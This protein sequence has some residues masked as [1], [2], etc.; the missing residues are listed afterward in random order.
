MPVA[1]LGRVKLGDMKLG[2]LD[3][4]ASHIGLT[5]RVIKYLTVRAPVTREKRHKVYT[6]GE[7]QKVYTL[8]VSQDRYNLE[9]GGE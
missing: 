5:R 9:D 7:S 3:A 2:W 4:P 6:L 1:D 8:G